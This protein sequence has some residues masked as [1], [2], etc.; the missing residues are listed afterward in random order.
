VWISCRICGA[1][2]DDDR[3]EEVDRFGGITYITIGTTYAPE[4]GSGVEGFAAKD[5]Q[6]EPRTGG[7]RNCYFCGG[8][9]RNGRGPEGL[10]L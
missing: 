5:L 10:I 3:T 7:Y 8:N 9:W 6:V 2:I 4:V 1:P